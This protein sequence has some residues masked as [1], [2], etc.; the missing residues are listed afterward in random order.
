MLSK[1]GMLF[2]SLCTGS[3]SI[4]MLLFAIMYSNLI[5]GQFLALLTAGCWANNS[6]TYR[7]LG[8]R[9]G[10]DAVAHIRMWV[11]LPAIV[12]LTYITEGTFFPLGLSA[13]TYLVLLLS[14]AIGYFITDMLVF[15]A[16]VWLGARESMIIMTLSPV[17]TAVFSFFLFNEILRPIQIFGILLTISGVILMVV[18]EMR[19]KTQI[20]EENAK[21]KAKGYIFAILGSILQA[22]A[23][24]LAKFALEST[25]PVS[26]NLV[27]NIGGLLTFFVYS[28]LIKRN[29]KAQFKA[30]K[31]PKFFLLLLTASLIGPVLGMSFQM[32]AFTLAPIGIVTTIAQISPIILLPIDKFIF[33]RKVT[34]SS[35]IGT[36][37]SLAGVALLFLAA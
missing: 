22:V 30:F 10:S 27:R 34:F 18:L 26:T 35:I 20:S 25:G 11:A 8:E 21:A 9:V 15:Y 13:Q 5:L 29:A 4:N 37:V 3:L 19:H 33:H 23:L 1:E 7:Y 32:K 31:N 36:F 14:G 24:I 17:A 12:L 16:F 2:C 28:F 6:V